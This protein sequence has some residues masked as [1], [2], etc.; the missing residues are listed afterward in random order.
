MK[1]CFAVSA[2]LL[3]I[4]SPGYT[5]DS[6]CSRDPHFNDFDFWLGEWNVTDSVSGNQAGHNTIAK[7]MASCL[8]AE[9]WQGSSGTGGKSLNY[10]NPLTRLWRQVWVAPGYAIDIAGGLKDGAMVL[11]GS[12]EYFADARYDFRG[13][14]TPRDDGSVR[15]LFEQYDPDSESWVVWFDGIYER[16]N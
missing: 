10:Y 9:T 16:Q 4:A 7:E 14:W 6:I 15:Q 1:T 2:I 12:I 13:T 5:Q 11:E 3:V 8:V